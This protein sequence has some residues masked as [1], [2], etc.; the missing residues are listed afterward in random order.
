LHSTFNDSGTDR[1]TFQQELSQKSGYSTGRSSV[2]A[3]H[4]QKQAESLLS[5]IQPDIFAFM[6]F[7]LSD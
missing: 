7:Y 3:P 2:F 5:V 4:K 1:K 6:K